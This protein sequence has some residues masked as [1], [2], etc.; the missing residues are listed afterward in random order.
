MI[1]KNKTKRL[2]LPKTFNSYLFYY[3]W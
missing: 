3:F 2:K 1:Q